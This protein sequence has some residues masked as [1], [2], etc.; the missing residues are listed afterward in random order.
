MKLRPRDRVAIVS[1]LCLALVA[2]YY[3][4]VLQPERNKAKALTGA[5]AAQRQ[6]LANE[7][8]QYAAGRAAQAA[9]RANAAEWASASIAVPA[10][11]DIPALLR[12]LERT[13]NAEHVKMQM[14]TVTAPSNSTTPSSST[15]ASS[16]TGSGGAAGQSI[17]LSFAGG[18]V[19]LEGLVQSLDRLVVISGGNVHASG[20]LI[21]I[22]GVNLSGTKSL[23]AQLNA[24][25]YQLNSTSS[26]G[27]AASTGGAQ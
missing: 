15:S 16:T 5:I 9:L 7:Q 19:P 20:P 1:L 2:A 21:T 24:D 4:L 8:Q 26:S 18:F 11:A 23:T 17:E 10:Q 6:D 22:S 27:G 14:L 12:T 13:A 3:L 25:I